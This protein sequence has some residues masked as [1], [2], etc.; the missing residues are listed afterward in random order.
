[1][2]GITG[3]IDFEHD[4]ANEQSLGEM[5]LALKHRGPDDGGLLIVNTEKCQVGLGHRRLSILDLS[6]A[7]R[8][9][10]KSARGRFVVVY[11][12]EIYNHTKLK[13][14]LTKLGVVFHS[15]SD[16]EILLAAV[17][18]WGLEPTLQKCAGMFAFALWDVKEQVLHLCRD[19]MGEKPLYYGWF[20]KTFLFASELKAMRRHPKWSGKID[21]IALG[22]LMR[23][24]YIPAPHS[25]HQGVSK[26]LPGHMI[27]IPTRTGPIRKV[28]P[29]PY[30]TLQKAI[31]NG[32]ANPFAGTET[33]AIDSIEKVLM[34]I[35]GEQMIADVPIG[36][37][38]SG[39]YDSSLVTSI[40]QASAK[41]PVQ[42][43]SIGFAE[44]KYDEAPYAKAV[45]E[46]LLT[47]HTEFYITPNDAMKVIPKLPDIYDEPFAD[48]SQIPTTILCALTRQNVTVALSGDGG[49]ELMRGYKHYEQIP[50]LWRKLKKIPSPLR[51]VFSQF[52]LTPP[53]F[54]YTLLPMIAKFK[55]GEQKLQNLALLA[56]ANDFPKFYELRLA[57]WKN[58]A[59]VV[60]GCPSHIFQNHPLL[61]DYKPK[62]IDHFMLYRDAL[63][64]LV[65]DILVKTDRAAM[66]VGLETR[67]PLIDHRLIEFI[68]SLPDSFR[69]RKT[70]DKWALRQVL[71]KHVPK[72]LVDRPKQG[73]TVPLG[74]WL[75]RGPV[76]EW[77][78]DILAESN[79][80]RQNALDKEV[81]LK[82][83]RMHLYGKDDYKDMLWPILMFLSSN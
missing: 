57:K 31:K 64:Y 11:N 9:P 25:I 67:M 12:G 38:L 37:F 30:W 81:V 47:K 1:M 16:T 42:T 6:P 14:E 74:E 28:E 73:F 3:F 22:L 55:K 36:A 34:E 71:Y 75:R 58:P 26:L 20:E 10:M 62:N 32:L 68:W 72:T 13:K 8:Q 48:Y 70:Y 19:R 35:V 63:S 17:E 83:W 60:C 53:K 49:D 77:A 24:M 54:S 56:L 66:N 2:C 39:G 43:F 18:Q 21:K 61:K 69:W 65:D 45:A 40:M 5:T 27:S 44:D 7:G 51:K 50:R 41:T 46:N 78:A 4:D 23:N 76:F 59:E 82:I 52:V 29:R 79:L 33:E 80:A 15:R